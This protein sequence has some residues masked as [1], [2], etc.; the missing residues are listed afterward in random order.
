MP[1]GRPYTEIESAH[2][3]FGLYTTLTV[4]GTILNPNTSP[5]DFAPPLQRWL[6]WQQ[7]TS[8]PLASPGRNEIDSRQVWRFTH[9]EPIIDVKAQ[10]LATTAISLHLGASTSHVPAGNKVLDIVYWFSILRSGL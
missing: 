2:W 6:W 8:A 10:V 3:T 5:S 9:V 1:A 7:L 4:G